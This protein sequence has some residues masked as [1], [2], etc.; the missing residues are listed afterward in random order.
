MGHINRT[1]S[2]TSLQFL[3]EAR[4]EHGFLS[5]ALPSSHVAV[6]SSDLHPFFLNLLPE[7]ARLRLLLEAS[8]SK[9]D[10]LGLLLKV[11]WDAIGDVSVLSPGAS[12]TDHIV[13]KQSQLA[14]VNFWDLFYAGVVDQI[15]SAV[16]GVQEKISASTIAF[17]VRTSNVPTGILKLN[18]ERFPLLVQ[19]EKFFLGVAK[20][21]GLEPNRATLVQ[22]RDGNAG[23]LVERFDRVKE[24]KVVRKLH[25]EDACQLLN[26]VPAHKYQLS[27]TNIAE[28]ISRVCT[29]PSVEIL[30]LLRLY[31]FSYIIGNGD[32]HGKNISVLWRET[33]GLSPA[34]DIL[35]TLPYPLDR[36]MA[37][38][39]DGRDDNFRAAHF[40]DFGKRFG[41]PERAVVLMIQKLCN[42]IEPWISRIDEIGF[43]VR[44]TQSMQ[45]E[46]G[47]RLLLILR[48]T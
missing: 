14:D 11:G 22:D 48:Q 46:I 17:G 45:Q 1:S 28:A 42:Q 8:K 15:D 12:L 47:N 18:P 20:S 34:Y 3:P 31:A 36:H 27:M 4:L 21:S 23:L 10:S 44:T 25:Q 7:G 30:R 37:L 5:T 35:S 43:E 13:A 29:A 6:E 40:V 33:V 16:P 19:N 41:V 32:L 39:L 24:G 38:K 26:T 9:D 2:G